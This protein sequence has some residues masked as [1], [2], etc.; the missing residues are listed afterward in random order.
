MQFAEVVLA[1]H[2]TLLAFNALILPAYAANVVAAV[3]VVGGCV[4]IVVA[5][6]AGSVLKLRRK[7]EANFCGHSLP[8][9]CAYAKTMRDSQ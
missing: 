6:A 5:A 3:V 1:T 7:L 8:R 2:L 4:V 9:I